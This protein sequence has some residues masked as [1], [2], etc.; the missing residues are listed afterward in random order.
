MA[1]V[2]AQSNCKRTQEN[3]DQPPPKR[4]KTGDGIRKI[5]VLGPDSPIRR[6]PKEMFIKGIF[7]YFKA[8]DLLTFERVCRQFYALAGD[9]PMWK[10]L[11]DRACLTKADSISFRNQFLSE[12]NQRNP[13]PKVT[14][15]EAEFFLDDKYIEID[16]DRVS[17]CYNRMI[18][19]SQ[20][21]KEVKEEIILKKAKMIGVD[22]SEYPF[23]DDYG[24]NGSITLQL[25]GVGKS[26]L[27]KKQVARAHLY[28]C[29]MQCKPFLEDTDQELM[30]NAKWE[31]T[32]QQLLK[33]SENDDA[34]PED[35][36]RTDLWLG[37]TE[38]RTP[39]DGET[40][41]SYFEPVSVN[42]QAFPEDRAE[43][44]FRIARLKINNKINNISD[45]E[46][47]Q[48]L[49]NVRRDLQANLR[50]RLEAAYYQTFMICENRGPSGMKREDAFQ[51]LDHLCNLDGWRKRAYKDMIDRANLLKISINA[52]NL[53]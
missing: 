20:I 15:S 11:F 24:E 35:R 36:A 8:K 44:M 30:F 27:S 43:A 4:I 46:A 42:P 3:F 18:I 9:A 10:E 37:L 41:F 17:E 50:T 22:F 40:T 51:I 25:H 28:T 45:S 33:V 48:Y 21:P 34:L 23:N 47:F 52:S 7:S 14:M 29:I 19:N 5:N 32:F 1:I 26:S 39:F 53:K 2:P 49:E 16:L 13:H 38:E 31:V 12:I 6:L